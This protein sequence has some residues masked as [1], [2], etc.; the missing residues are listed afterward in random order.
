MTR[1]QVKKEFIRVISKMENFKGIIVKLFML[2]KKQNISETF[3]MAKSA[4]MADII[5]ATEECGKDNGKT[6]D[7]MVMEN[8]R[9]KTEI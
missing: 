2:I 5:M 8:L 6:I 4:V 1:I 9:T 7:K 3:K